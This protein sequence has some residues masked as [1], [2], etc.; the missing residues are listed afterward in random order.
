M[1]RNHPTHRPITRYSRWAVLL[2]ASC[3]LVALAAGTAGAS[4]VDGVATVS[5]PGATTPLT[6]G[7]SQ[8]QFGLT[9]PALA[10]CDGDTATH[11]YHIYSYLVPEGT[12]LSSLTFG[13]HPSTGYGLYESTGKY[14]GAVNTAVNTGQVIGVP[15][16]FEW[17]ELV[18]HA[19]AMLS[20]LLYTGSGSSATGVWEAGLACANSSG[21][22]ADNWNIVVTFA[23]DAS[24]P[25]GFT[26]TAIA[27]GSKAAAFTSAAG[28][29]FT[30][31]SSGSFIPTA[32]GSPAPTITETGA[33]PAGVSFIGGVLKGSPS[34]TGKFPISF[35]ATNG[36]GSPVTQSFT[37]TVQAESSATTT[38]TTTTTVTND[39]SGSTTTTTTAPGT[40]TTT[41]PSSTGGTGGTSTG[42]GTDGASTGSGASTGTGTSA[43]AFTGFHTAKGLGVGL[44]GVGLGLMLLGWGYRKKI[45][46]ARL[47]RRSTP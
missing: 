35:T 8:T 46:P 15:N 20:T 40:S 18:T 41:D 24:D 12:N 10:A 14:W 36:I 30:V 7:G 3:V 5:P 11:G 31:G 16:D 38:T 9:L 4:T 29:T 28:A 2:P 47:A 25:N 37:L 17:A 26:W 45:R 19:G 32:S 6:S 13:S 43:L 39:T 27:S 44:L 1:T 21:A 42:G 22:L 33:L 34:V 23:A